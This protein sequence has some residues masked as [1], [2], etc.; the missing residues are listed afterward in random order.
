MR[1]SC[2]TVALAV[3]VALA[4]MP[5][6]ADSGGWR[7]STTLYGWLT[8]LSA[9][10]GTP[11][12]TIAVEQ[13]FSDVFDQLDFAV[14]GSFEARQGNWALIGDLAHAD[15]SRTE[16]FPPAAPFGG[17]RIDTRL[18]A[19]SGYAAY[20]VVE[21]GTVGLD[22]AAGLRHYDLS[23]RAA[24]TGPSLDVGMSDSWTDPVIAARAVWEIGDGWRGAVSLDTG[25][26]GIGS[27]SEL[28]WQVAAEVEYGFSDRWS[29]LFGYRHLSI[30]RP[31]DGREMKLELSGPLIGVRAR[32]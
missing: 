9:S 12:G 7:Y 26:F 1:R 5:A 24:L 18:T 30:D 25:G 14:F 3:G 2:G 16:T 8:S 29:V 28:S 21:T 17:A 10:V 32:F 20:R 19:I 27:A 15:L 22:L 31:A 6:A 23:L 13:S 4:G 11:R